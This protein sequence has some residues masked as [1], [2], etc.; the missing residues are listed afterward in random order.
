[1]I[2]R[3]AAMSELL[4]CYPEYIAMRCNIQ[5]SLPFLKKATE[6][7]YSEQQDLE[8]YDEYRGNAPRLIPPLAENRISQHMPWNIVK[9]TTIA[10]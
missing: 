1:M 5:P 8:V 10:L 2:S 3:T 7:A 4:F 6:W 9:R